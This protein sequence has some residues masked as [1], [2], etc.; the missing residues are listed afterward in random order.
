[1]ESVHLVFILITKNSYTTHT[2]T[3]KRARGGG[4]GGVQGRFEKL[5]G[6][7]GGVQGRFEKLQRQ[8]DGQ[9][10]GVGSR[11]LNPGKRKS[12]DHWT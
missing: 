8:H 1:M 7:G 5:Q 11:Q 12:A 4:G 6:G 3:Y 2:H 9:K 10:E